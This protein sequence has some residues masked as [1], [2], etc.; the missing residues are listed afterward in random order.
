MSNFYDETQNTLMRLEKKMD[1]IS[2]LLKTKGSNDP[3]H[4]FFDNQEFL[5][6]MNISKKTAQNWRDRGI[7]ISTPIGGKIYYKLSNIL[8]LINERERIT[9]KPNKSK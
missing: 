5:Q 7:I 8:K 6:V 4:I 2:A 9:V 1:E 3:E